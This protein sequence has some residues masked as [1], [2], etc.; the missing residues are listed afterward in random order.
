MA[1][2]YFNVAQISRL[3]ATS[4]AYDHLVMPPRKKDLICSI[5]KSHKLWASSQNDVVSVKGKGLLIL[6]SGPP[7]VGKTLCAEAIA[8]KLCRPLF[9]VSPSNFDGTK[10]VSE[11]LSEFLRR[12]N[13]WNAILLVDEA[14]LFLRKRGNDERRNA[15][16]S[17]FLWHLERHK[18]VVFL[19]T[20][21]FHELDIAVESR[22]H[23]HVQ[24]SDLDRSSRRLIWSRFVAR[25]PEVNDKI[26]Q[27]EL[28]ELA[29][30]RLNGRQI[31]NALMM[32]RAWCLETSTDL[33]VT[34]IEEIIDL[35]F[36]NTSREQDDVTES[37]A[38]LVNGEST[39]SAK[40]DL[41]E[42]I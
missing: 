22:A 28:D 4:E 19:V 26:G 31:K 24:F 11:K 36:P 20:N 18:G 5:V 8:D 39:R 13:D 14:D 1:A 34:V 9:V 2:G 7:G 30:W 3:T 37:G 32:A 17:A 12:A 33:S 27:S 15:T 29:K 21:L 25:V 40:D 6:L 16:V 41:L 10:S 23:I 35:A 38:V 42:L